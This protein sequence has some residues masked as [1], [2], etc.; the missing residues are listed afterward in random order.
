MLAKLI[1][2]L[3]IYTL[4]LGIRTGAIFSSKAKRWVKGRKKIFDRIELALEKVQKEK[5]HRKMAWFHCASLGEFEQGRPVIEK[6][7]RQYPDYLI[8]LTFFSPSGYEVRCAYT[9]ADLVFYLPLD[10]PL[11]AK[12]F[13]ELVKPDVAF[14]VKYEFWF[15]Y[16]DELQKQQIPLFLVSGNFRANQLFF[17]WYG[18]WPRRLLAGFSVIFVQNENSRELLEF[19]NIRNVIISGD[20]RFD[21]VA[22]IAGNAHVFPLIRDFSTGKRTII[23]GSTWPA[24]EELLLRYIAENHNVNL[25]IAPHQIDELHVISIVSKSNGTAVRLSVANP[26]SITMYRILIIDTI[27]ILPHLYQY[28]T[29]AYVGGGFGV[30]IHNILEAATFGL[31]VI[32]GP[33]YQKFNEATDLVMLKGAFP[34]ESYKELKDK[35]SQLLGHSSQYRAAASVCRNYVE[36]KRGATEIV[37]GN[38]GQFIA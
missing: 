21:R 32:F 3:G 35:I 10:T 14:F 16:L 1:Y 11:R 19:L 37:L 2:S 4:G 28:G 27:G 18:E 6:F 15:N 24:D 34:V 17:K 30:G 38:I 23:A 29:V 12:R 25:I 26:S 31:P 20:T 13:V 7:R 5:G 22:D 33:N 8:F 9:G 36:H